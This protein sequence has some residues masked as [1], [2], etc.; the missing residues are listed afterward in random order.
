MWGAERSG[1]EEKMGEM[2]TVDRKRERAKWELVIVCNKDSE[3][4]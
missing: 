1:V 3:E 2:E 4:I